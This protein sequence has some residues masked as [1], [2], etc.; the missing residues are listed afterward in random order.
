MDKRNASLKKAKTKNKKQT[1]KKLFHHLPE[2]NSFSSKAH[3]KAT[4]GFNESSF[5]NVFQKNK[6]FVGQREK[7]KRNV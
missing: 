1:V 4:T 6:I 5:I 3:D 7:V 2:I